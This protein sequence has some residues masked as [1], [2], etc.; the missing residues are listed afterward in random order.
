MTY[1]IKK[2]KEWEKFFLLE[3]FTAIVRGKV[4]DDSPPAELVDN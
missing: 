3:Y 1:Y 4:Q 2:K